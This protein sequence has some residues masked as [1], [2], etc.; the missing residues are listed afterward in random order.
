MASLPELL[1]APPRRVP[2]GRLSE[3]LTNNAP[4]PPP[5]EQQFQRDLQFA[6]G[7]RDW[8]RDFIRSEGSEPNTDPGGDYNYRLAWATGADPEYHAASNSFHGVSEAVVPPRQPIP[9]KSSG[10]PTEWKAKFFNE[11][12]FDP[13]VVPVEQW[14]P[15]QLA[16]A[17]QEVGRSYEPVLRAGWPGYPASE[18]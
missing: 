5:Y 11:F 6:P 9:L 18:R 14:R 13:D 16:F 4:L 2:T 12:G 7:W 8:R 1:G 3:L 17:Q 15:E 10:H